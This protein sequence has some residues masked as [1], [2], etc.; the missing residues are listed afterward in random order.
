[1]QVHPLHPLA[2]PMK[3][4]QQQKP[5][6]REA[7]HSYSYWKLA[8]F[9]YSACESIGGDKIKVLNLDNEKAIAY[10]GLRLSLKTPEVS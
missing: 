5:A 1:M 10:T 9:E 6:S 2:T 3:G 4:L 7:N 8:V